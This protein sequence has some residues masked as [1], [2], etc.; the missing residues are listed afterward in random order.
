MGSST[1]YRSLSVNTL[2]TTLATQKGLM[3]LLLVSDS[4]GLCYLVENNL[5]KL[6]DDIKNRVAIFKM[7]HNANREHLSG[8][9]ILNTPTLLFF[10]EGQLID[11]LAGVISKNELITKIKLY[12]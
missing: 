6:P 9:F 3:L 4:N 12:S 1:A 5:K 8:Y 10:Q 2:K 11:K 7:D